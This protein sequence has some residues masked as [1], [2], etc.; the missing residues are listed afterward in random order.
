MKLQVQSCFLCHHFVYHDDTI[1]G[2][3]LT[4]SLSICLSI[5]VSFSIYFSLVKFSLNVRC[6]GISST[7]IK[8]DLKT[9]ASCYWSVVLRCVVMTMNRTF[10]MVSISNVNVKCKYQKCHILNENHTCKNMYAQLHSAYY[11]YTYAHC[12]CFAN[13][14]N[15]DKPK[16]Q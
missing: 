3:S 4:F 9:S 13:N 2:P 7:S 1:H 11:T 5:S 8:L 16:I 14:S 10:I 15:N 6:Y 12:H